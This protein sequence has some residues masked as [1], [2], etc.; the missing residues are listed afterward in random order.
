MLYELYLNGPLYERL[1]GRPAPQAGSDAAGPGRPRYLREYGR[2]L[3]DAFAAGGYDYVTF[4]STTIFPHCG[5]RPTS[6]ERIRSHSLNDRPVITG[7]D[8]LPRYRWPSA[9]DLDP[10]AL[11]AATAEIPDSMQAMMLAPGGIL[12]NLVDLLGYDRLCFALVDDR[13]LVRRV[14]R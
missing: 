1:A 9:D 3:S 8:D 2:W 4:G 11:D 10:A 13:E 7:W 6:H 12:E 5:F 14:A